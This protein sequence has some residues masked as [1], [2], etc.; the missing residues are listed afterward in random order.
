MP[1]IVPIRLGCCFGCSP[2]SVF[3]NVN[4][5]VLIA[6]GLA[7]DARGRFAKGSSGNPRGRPPGIRNPKRR[8]P[9]LV[10]RPLSQE[11]LSALLERKPHLLRPLAARFMPPPVRAVDP[12]ERLGIDLP[13]SPT[14]ADVQGVLH[15][16]LAALA[17][18]QITL[19]DAEYIARA[20][21]ARVCAVR[22]LARGAGREAKGG[23]RC[24]SPALR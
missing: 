6:P 9:D 10:A 16:V 20:T 12:M 19:G 15:T 3:R 5:L 24:A 13:S 17:R 23:L 21:H 2:N 14:P 11:A 1:Q 4:N 7:R 8:I 18:G 22:R